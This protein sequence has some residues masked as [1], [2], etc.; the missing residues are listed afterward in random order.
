MRGQSLAV[1]QVQV[2]WC[3]IVCVG[4]LALLAVSRTGVFNVQTLSGNVVVNNIAA[5]HYGKAAWTAVPR[6]ATLWYH[7][8]DAVSS[9]V[10]AEDASQP[11]AK[12]LKSESSGSLR[13][14]VQLL[15]SATEATPGAAMVTVPSESTR[16]LN[17]RS[18]A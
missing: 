16:N 4:P 7:A 12:A 3:A 18:T 8:V 15:Q 6:L 14:L 11:E 2:L 5:T 1:L 17:L 10:G 9:V 13:S